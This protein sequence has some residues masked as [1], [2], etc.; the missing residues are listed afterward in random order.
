[1]LSIPILE[2]LGVIFNIVTFY[3]R[4]RRILG[5]NANAAIVLRTDSLTAALTLPAESQQSPLLVAAYQWLI[6]RPEFQALRAHV[7]VAHLFGDANPY[8]DSISRQRWAEFRRRCAQIGVR[9]TGVELPAPVYDAYDLVSRTAH[10]SALRAGSRPGFLSRRYG[11]EPPPPTSPPPTPTASTSA[12]Q[13]GFLQR[14]FG[15]SARPRPRAASAPTITSTTTDEQ[16]SEVGHHLPS[17][18]AAAPSPPSPGLRDALD[19]HAARVRKVHGLNLPRS[20]PARTTVSR[21]SAA[22]RHFAR[23][24]MQA[25]AAGDDDMALRSDVVALMEVGDAVQ[26]SVDYGVNANTAQKDERAWLFWETICEQQ[27][28]SPLRTAQE[29]RDHPERQAHLLAVLMLYAFAV[30][31]PRDTTRR[32]VKPRSALAYPLAIIRIFARWGI[33]MPGYKALVAAMN[34]LMRL[35]IA[36]HGHHSLA[37]RRAEPMKFVMMCAIFAVGLEGTTKVGRWIWTD[38]DHDVFMFRRLNVFMMY[39]AFRAGEI[40]KHTSGEIMFIT[41]ACLVWSIGGVLIVDPT[42]GQL[43][44]LRPGIDYAGVAPPRSKPDPWGEIHCPFPVTLTYDLEPTN[45]A[46]QLRD[47]ELRC[48]CHGVERE[49]RP[50]F[51]D[52]SGQPYTHHYLAIMLT[53]ALTFLYGSAVA[54][55]HTLH[56]Y[57]SGLATALHA[58]HVPDAMIQLICR[59]MCPESLHVYRRMGTREH[60]SHIRRASTSNVDVIQST[61]VVRVAADEG[62]GSLVA[63]LQGA[64]GKDAQRDYERTLEAVRAAPTLTPARA[65]PTAARELSVPSTGPTT[66]EIYELLKKEDTVFIPKQVWPAEPCHEHAGLGWAAT[67]VS[68]TKHTALVRFR[69]ARAA[70]GAP[71]M[72][73]RLQTNV[74]RRLI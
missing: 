39:T 24:R 6:A 65:H 56:S 59:W 21:L 61:N 41:R 7:F 20:P 54:A 34:G 14:R 38:D 9:P 70:N 68:A 1:M 17:A 51:A 73:E 33:L 57:R 42:P 25:M 13:S 67:V 28:T 69:Y 62:Y 43:A 66:V 16:R 12:L 4:L 29:A 31:T 45:P 11:C 63:D 2:F 40:V 49:T 26:E 52:T 71:F 60:D 3:P 44:A 32:F 23:V 15:N 64:R 30:C 55:L 53:A 8:S 22:S 18:R 27:G 72:D 58:A 48:P 50:L 19:I 37:P 36:Y 46:A 10:S 47:I 35:Y 74:L 5:S